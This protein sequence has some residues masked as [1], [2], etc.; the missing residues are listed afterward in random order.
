MT[1]LD[2]GPVLRALTCEWRTVESVRAELYGPADRGARR[3]QAAAVR[4]RLRLL[5]GQ[6]LAERGLARTARRTAV[7]RRTRS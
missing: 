3:L 2:A 1:R 7:W 5:E 4:R 6:G